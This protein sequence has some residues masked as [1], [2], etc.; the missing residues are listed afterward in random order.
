VEATELI[1]VACT[2]QFDSDDEDLSVFTP[3]QEPAPSSS[4]L[5][6]RYAPTSSAANPF[7][8]TRGTY[9]PALGGQSQNPASYGGGQAANQ[10]GTAVDGRGAVGRYDAAEDDYNPY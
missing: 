5:A 9:D 8:N 7:S 1:K 10:F 6:S 3:G 2:S 4:R